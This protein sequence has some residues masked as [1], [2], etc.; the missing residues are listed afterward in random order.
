M[1]MPR[2][3]LMLMAA[4][5]LPSQQQGAAFAHLPDDVLRLIGSY[6]PEWMHEQEVRQRLRQWG[7]PVVRLVETS[8]KDDKGTVEKLIQ[9]AVARYYKILGRSVPKAR[10]F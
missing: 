4:R 9:V 10:H 6:V 1:Q 7:V 3:H 8:A 2:V 5:R